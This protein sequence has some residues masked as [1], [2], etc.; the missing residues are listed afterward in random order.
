MKIIAIIHEGSL[1]MKTKM[2]IKWNHIK[3]FKDYFSISTFLGL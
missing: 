3:F 2:N 1:D